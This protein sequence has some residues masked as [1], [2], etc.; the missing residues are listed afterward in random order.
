MTVQL[1][2]DPFFNFLFAVGS[3][4]RSTDDDDRYYINPSTKNHR[5]SFEFFFFPFSSE[6]TYP[7]LENQKQTVVIRRR[8]KRID[9]FVLTTT[10]ATTT[11]D[12]TITNII[13]VISFVV[14]KLYHQRSI[15]VKE[16]RLIL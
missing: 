5:P 8:G 6:H 14:V 12:K 1:F 11:P 4:R 7:S 16:T 13:V 15:T 9:S 10:A 2:E 3:K